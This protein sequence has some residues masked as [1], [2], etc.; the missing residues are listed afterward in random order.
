M[1]IIRTS[2]LPAPPTLA[3]IYEPS[4]EI[5]HVTERRDSNLSEMSLEMVP[6]RELTGL[7]ATFGIEQDDCYEA[8]ELRRK[9]EE[10]RQALKL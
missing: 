2:S 9:I 10:K 5:T 7:A 8:A 3:P 6:V 4:E 1:P